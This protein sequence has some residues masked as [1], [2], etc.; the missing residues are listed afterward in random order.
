MGV[1]QVVVVVVVVVGWKKKRNVQTLWN[2]LAAA[3]TEKGE[4]ETMLVLLAVCGPPR[5]V[6]LLHS[7][8]IQDFFWSVVVNSTK[9][10]FD[11][12]CTASGHSAKAQRK[13]E[14][15]Y[16]TTKLHILRRNKLY[17]FMYLCLVTNICSFLLLPMADQ[18][19]N[20]KHLVPNPIPWN[21]RPKCKR[22]QRVA[23]AG[24]PSW[25]LRRRIV[26][27]PFSSW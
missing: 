19:L 4:G 2:L 5:S 7:G 25:T 23:V 27:N 11:P 21:T 6:W 15:D 24:S 13:N 10:G 1:E 8:Q 14:I 3:A 18:M 22:V 16:I 17:F 9:D 20:G 12:L 26:V